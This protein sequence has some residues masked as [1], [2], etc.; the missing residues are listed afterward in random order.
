MSNLLIWS[1]LYLILT[2]QGL[3]PV[4]S[5][6]PPPGLQDVIPEGRNPTLDLINS[7]TIQ[8]QRS[9]IKI[10]T[11]AKTKQKDMFNK[12]TALL[13]DKAIKQTTVS[14]LNREFL[15]GV[16]LTTADLPRSG[17]PATANNDVTQE[18]ALDYIADHDG[19]RVSEL[20]EFLD[21][22]ESSV[23]RILHELGFNFVE[24]KYVPYRLTP[25]Q[26]IQRTITAEQNLVMYR[27]IHNFLLKI[28]TID[29]TWLPQYM[30]V[31]GARR[32]QWVGP[33]DEADP[34]PRGYANTFKV[35]VVVAFWDN[36]VLAYAYLPQG[37][38]MNQQRF[39]D[40][41]MDQFLAASRRNRIHNPYILMDNA[42]YHF[43]DSVKT[44]M[45]EQ[46]WK[47]LRQDAYSPD[48]NPCDSHGFRMLKQPLQGRR[49][50]NRDEMIQA[51]EAEVINF[52]QRGTFS[53]IKKLPETWQAIIDKNGE[54]VH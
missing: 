9:W 12:L 21:V 3:D 39:K 10:E 44:F 27:E 7:V 35:G 29:E 4:P 6:T 52:N 28:I 22:S 23:N 17:R 43:T 25:T 54:Y 48:E 8:E 13:G 18:R 1:S 45:Q 46:N 49:F 31:T 50:N 34:I 24:S 14:K 41:L 30:P 37:E 2:G 40:F 32:G 26:K 51:F 5:P 38:N 11:I 47:I 36:K 16:R 19:A 33:G 42:R 20:A 15:D 53:G